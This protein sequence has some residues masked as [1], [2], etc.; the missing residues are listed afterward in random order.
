[1]PA[2][3]PPT[4]SIPRLAQRPERTPPNVVE[5][6]QQPDAPLP[7]VTDPAV[8]AVSVEPATPVIPTTATYPIDL[9]VALRLADVENPEIAGARARILGAL[10][11]QQAARVLLLPTLNAGVTYHG[12]TGNLIRSA[13]RILSLSEQSLYIGGGARTLA[14]ETI[15]VPMVNVFSPITEAWF[16]PLVTHQRV[17][18]TEA[19]AVGTANSVLREVADLY[20]ELLGAEARLE[21]MRISQAQT[22]EI[23][24]VVNSYAMA[25][26]GR[27]ADARRAAVESQ[28]RLAETQRFEGE[29]ATASAHLAQRLN[30]DPSVRLEAHLGPLTPITLIDPASDPETLT[31]VALQRRPE[32]VARAAEIAAVRYE[33]QEELARPL[34]PT[35]WLGFS[36]GAFGGGSNLSEPLLGRFSGRTDFDIRLVWTVLN[37]GE[38]NV[39]R[40]R[41]RRAQIGEAVGEQS[42]MANEVRREVASALAT[43]KARANQ[44][45]TARVQLSVAEMGF[46]EDFS[47]ARQN[48]G[49]PIEVLDNLE[50]LVNARIRLIEAITQYNQAQFA[51]FVALGSPPP[52]PP[53]TGEP[54][55]P[56]PVTTPIHQPF[57][58][59][60]GL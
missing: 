51:L 55:A 58:P 50:H 34:L 41:R 33:F 31:Q 22:A 48:L 52:L 8:P 11:E 18:R 42:V 59:G 17:I 45:Q 2:L 28:L 5:E 57:V 16:E 4:P 40:W 46:N 9:S 38:G 60:H 47:R 26:E 10:A 15:N 12:H 35:V 27:E 36:A 32:L 49:R 7:P 13:G 25:G 24:R 20:L 54:E 30:L 23:A 56:P 6:L 37:L 3:S 1:M 14:A 19:A 21:A 43:M 29:V 53:P 39:A 44:I